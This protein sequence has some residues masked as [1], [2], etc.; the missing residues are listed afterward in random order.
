MTKLYQIKADLHIHTKDD[1]YDTHITQSANDI[2]RKGVKCNPR[3]DCLAFTNHDTLTLNEGILRCA[4]DNKTIIIPGLEKFIEGRHILLYVISDLKKKKSL[5]KIK[6]FKDLASFKKDG[7]VDLVIAAHP[8]YLIKEN[9]SSKLIKH[10][11]LF[12]AIEYSW[13]YSRKFLSRCNQKAMDIAKKYNKPLISTSD[14]HFFC[15]FGKNYS[16]IQA[17]E[18]TTRG[19]IEAIKEGRVEPPVYNPA[20]TNEMI[21]SLLVFPFLKLTKVVSSAISDQNQGEKNY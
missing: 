9:L 12:D 7:L 3:F 18:R 6:T 1:R 14:A 21:L 4:Q 11:D 13:F 17:K 15:R 5:L 8:F 10:I 20:T 19:V 16:I 2:I